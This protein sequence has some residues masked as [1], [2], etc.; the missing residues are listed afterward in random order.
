[1]KIGIIGSGRI[2][3]TFGGLWAKAGHEVMFSDRD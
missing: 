2:G 3:S 1:M